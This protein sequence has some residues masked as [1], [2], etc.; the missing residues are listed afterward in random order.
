ME[1]IG[2][3]DQKGSRKNRVYVPEVRVVQQ[4][5]NL[6]ESMLNICVFTSQRNIQEEAHTTACSG[7]GG[8]VIKTILEQQPG[9]IC[10]LS[11]QMRKTCFCM[12]LGAILTSARPTASKNTYTTRKRCVKNEAAENEGETPTGTVLLNTCPRYFVDRPWMALR[13]SIQ[14][15]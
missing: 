1:A 2:C 13:V 8:V 10:N 7:I 5:E 6:Y 9:G 3:L 14:K 12:D 11:N 15:V 4:A